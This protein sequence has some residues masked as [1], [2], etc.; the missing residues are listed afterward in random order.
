MKEMATTS[1]FLGRIILLTFLALF[2]AA[3]SLTMFWHHSA[4]AYD[5]GGIKPTGESR[6]APKYWTIEYRQT[7]HRSY[8]PSSLYDIGTYL[9]SQNDS[10]MYE[11]MLFVQIL[12]IL[13][14]MVALLFIG[15]CL[16]DERMASLVFRAILIVTS[17][18]TI[19]SFVLSVP[20]ALH[21]S[22]FIGTTANEAAGGLETYGPLPGL[23]YASV[24]AVVQIPAVILR[25]H[26]ARTTKNEYRDDLRVGESVD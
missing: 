17:T 12:V 24:A 7:D 11:V 6:F 9:Y 19:L 4:Y 18:A 10:P 21:L 13:W 5:S 14:F 16:L 15:L 22:G 8:P 23:W 2:L 3:L 26:V 25:I 20:N 1:R